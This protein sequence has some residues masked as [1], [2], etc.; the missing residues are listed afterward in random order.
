MKELQ[1]TSSGVGERGTAKTLPLS[2]KGRI[3]VVDA[4]RGVGVG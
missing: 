3:G 4:T 2:G 1:K